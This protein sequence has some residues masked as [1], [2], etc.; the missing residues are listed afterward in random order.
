M[1]LFFLGAHG[2]LLS[3]PAWDCEKI[4]KISLRI[5]GRSWKSYNDKRK[6]KAGDMQQLALRLHPWALSVRWHVL[7]EMYSIDGVVC[8]A[9][10]VVH[11]LSKLLDC[12]LSRFQIQ[13]EYDK[14]FILVSLDI[15]II[16]T[17]A[18][19]FYVMLCYVM[20]CY[21][22]LCYVMLCYV[23]LCYVMLCFVML[24]Y[25]ILCYVMLCYVM[26]CY[27]MLC[28]KYSRG[29]HSAPYSPACM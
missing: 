7:F 13:V 9:A 24:C 28:P 25:V 5:A 17:S 4:I 14:F 8:S 21:V 12:N 20:L 23:M 29:V 2:T 1:C 16:L 22:M 26:L 15:P 10:P 11:W 27:V 6:T 18:S 19:P 3:P